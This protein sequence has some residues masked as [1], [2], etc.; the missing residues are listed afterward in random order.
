[1]AGFRFDTRS[2]ADGRKSGSGRTC[3]W[4]RNR[5][6]FERVI[7][8]V[9]GSRRQ[10]TLIL[11][12]HAFLRSWLPEDRWSASVQ[13]FFLAWCFI[14]D[15][16]GTKARLAKASVAEIKVLLSRC[17]DCRSLISWRRVSIWRRLYVCLETCS[18]HQLENIADMIIPFQHFAKTIDK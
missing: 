7:A 13:I 16:A 2:M 14:P 11:W 5:L 3:R 4:T 12:P 15:W 17:S 6:V 10:G 9:R 18:K 8:I 1:M